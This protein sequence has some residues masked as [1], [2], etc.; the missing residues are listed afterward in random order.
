MRYPRPFILPSLALTIVAALAGPSAAQDV[1]SVSLLDEISRA[2]N[3][4]ADAPD[5]LDCQLAEQRAIAIVANAVAEA[6]N[7]KDRGTFIEPVRALLQDGIPEI[8]TAAVYALA[9]LGP[10]AGDTPVLRALLLDPI[11]NVRA[12]AWSA[13][14]ASSDPAAK[15]LS[16]RV[17]DPPQG[18]GYAPDPLPFDPAA[19]AI[20]VPVDA[21]YLW[22]TSATRETGQLHFLTQESFD[23]TLAQF[24]HLAGTQSQSLPE[25]F[26]AAAPEVVILGTFFD[27]RVFATP[28]VVTFDGLTADDP[29]WHVVIYTDVAFGQTG[30]ALVASDGRNLRPANPDTVASLE[31]QALP[32]DAAFDA[33]LLERAGFKPDADPEESDLFMAIVAADGYGAEG[34]LEVF[35]DGAYAAE[36]QAYLDRPRLILDSLSY[37]ET[38]DIGISFQNLPPGSS[39]LVRVQSMADYAVVAEPFFPDA[40]ASGLVIEHNGGLAPGVYQVVAEVSLG[41]NSGEVTLK[42][43]FSVEKSVAVLSLDKTE[44]RP[45]EK[46]TIT[47]S[48]MLGDDQDY[49]ATA[50]AGSANGNYLQ[51]TYTQSARDGV[52][53]LAAPTAPGNYEVR[54]FFRE[55]ESVLRGMVPFTVT[56]TASP[57]G[58]TPA[59]VTTTPAQPDAEARATLA[60]DKSEYEPGSPITVTFAGM[61]GSTQ[62]YVSTAPA[63]SPN[64]TYMQYTY[65]NAALEGTATLTA[66]AQPGTYEVRAFF[67]EDETILRASVPFTVSGGTIEPTPGELTDAARA[68]L[69]LDQAT[70][71]PGESVKVTYSD[72]YGDRQDYVAISAAGTPNSSYLQYVYTE[73][74]REGTAT[75]TAPTTPGTYEVR[76]F[77][78]EDETILRASVPFTVE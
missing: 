11:S 36:A 50:Q 14:S 53:T 76:A 19:L 6:G 62:D 32:D 29:P 12:G 72:M 52:V 46:I 58:P 22:I 71:A 27:P 59:T 16:R 31:P 8:R 65:V 34:Y 5:T 30:F 17:P 15:A 20:N 75:L 25:L 9:K 1:E 39:A 40:L 35:P 47:F 77:F 70:Y 42:R 26:E 4:C 23:A 10:D 78:K 44:Y 63:G 21:Q 55:D 61:S 56:G 51:Y 38:T 67:R 45:G 28:R 2:K 57:A 7:S 73:A 68:T 41:D 24:E 64:S 48:G 13:A 3:L 33:A 18:E 74:K 43:D 60:L 37:Y 49:V 66:P 54:A 69:S